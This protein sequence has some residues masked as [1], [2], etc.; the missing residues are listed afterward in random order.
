MDMKTAHYFI[1][2]AEEKSISKAAKRL[3]LS[4]PTLS[5]YLRKLESSV[6]TPLF[7]R[8]KTLSLT[9]AGEVYL[10]GVR[11][12][13]AI[14]NKMYREIED[15][16]ANE[17]A[18][19][20]VGLMGGRSLHFLSKILPQLY[21]HYPECTV[22]V[23]EGSSLEILGMMR[24]GRLDFCILPIADQQPSLEYAM[25]KQ[26]EILLAIPKSNPLS[27]FESSAPGE[28]PS[29]PIQRLEEEFFIM[30]GNTTVLRMRLDRY[31]QQHHFV[32]KVAAE[33]PNAF[34]I[35][36]LANSG[37]AIGFCPQDD[38]YGSSGICYASLADPLFQELYLIHKKYAYLT[39]PMRFFSQLVLENK[40]LL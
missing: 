31:F 33:A 12:I 2:I 40:S 34:S 27:T 4:Q 21:S 3:Y 22:N 17:R 25:L 10:K 5:S 16:C 15:I 11:K 18:L 30:P 1:A 29:I 37:V 26:E 13:V 36:N 8:D 9:P 35:L 20:S 39:K 23:L 38:T 14:N 7:Y 19:F 28:L 6:G 32:P 24:E